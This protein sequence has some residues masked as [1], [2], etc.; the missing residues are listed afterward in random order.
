MWGDG[1]QTRSFMFVE[2]CV[3]GS[4][5]IMNS[6][7]EVTPARQNDTQANAVGALLLPLAPGRSLVPLLSPPDR[8]P[9]GSS[10]ASLASPLASA[11][12][13]AFSG[14]RTAAARL[15]PPPHPPGGGGGGG[16]GA[17]RLRWAPGG[18]ARCL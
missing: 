9:T 4:L 2:D 17:W 7:C 14:P 18:G 13:V 11:R 3:E 5:R 10:L 15:G 6:D 16:G 8:N 1:E 12:P